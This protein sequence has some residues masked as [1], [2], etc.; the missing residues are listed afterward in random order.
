MITRRNLLT[1]TAAGM[2]S[3]ATLTGAAAQSGEPVEVAL[4]APMTGPWARQGELMLKGAELAIK[5]INA[6]GGVASL[7]GRPLELVVF[8]TGDSA[9]KAKNA[10]QRMVSQHP[11]LVGVSGA[12]LSSFTLAISEVTERAELPMLTFSVSDQITARGF[13]YIFQTPLTGG[14]QA[15]LS[16][17]ALIEVSQ[18]ATGNKPTKAG[19]LVDNTTG[20]LSFAKPLREGLLKDLGIDLAFDE[21]F[22]PPLA[23]ATSLIQQVRSARP[24]FLIMISTSVPDAKLLLEKISEFNLGNGRL[25]IISSGA[26]MGTPELLK[27]VG[28]EQLEGVMSV[29]ANWAGKGLE[30]VVARFEKE[31]GEPWITQDSITTYADIQLIKYALEQSG[32]ADRNAVAEAL[33][34]ID[35]TGGPAQYYAGHHLKFDE[36][37]HNVGAKLVIF[38]WQNSEPIAIYP[39]DSALAQPIWPKQ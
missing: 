3:A 23:D 10:A 37:G 34:A 29:V 36:A 14:Q 39:P 13:K 27:N 12:W 20:S 30:E 35:T 11:G 22:T 17:P 18:S 1:M 7:G 26:A 16:V 15:R 24:D 2:L 6:A 21:T 4:I 9:E 32:K 31:T 5:D 33:R 19:I 28:K 8:D 38:Q 25:P